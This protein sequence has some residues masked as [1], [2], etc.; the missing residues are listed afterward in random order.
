MWEEIQLTFVVCACCCE[1]GNE[2]SGSIKCIDF[3]FHSEGLLPNS[4]IIYG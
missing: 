2:P 3:A 4:V 1:H